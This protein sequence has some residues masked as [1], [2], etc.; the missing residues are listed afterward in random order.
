[1]VFHHRV[2]MIMTLITRIMDILFL[3]MVLNRHAL[4]APL[5]FYQLYLAFNFVRRVFPS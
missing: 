5:A 3:E 1:M 2:E 4:V